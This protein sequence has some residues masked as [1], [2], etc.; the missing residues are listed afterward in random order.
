MA[1]SK[2]GLMGRILLAGGRNVTGVHSILIHRIS[3]HDEGDVNEVGMGR[4]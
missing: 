4:K 3:E 1:G 2:E